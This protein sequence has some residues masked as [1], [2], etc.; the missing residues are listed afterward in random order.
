MAVN[1]KRLNQF[2]EEDPSLTDQFT[3]EE[4]QNGTVVSGDTDI[5]MEDV[6]SGYCKKRMLLE[7]SIVD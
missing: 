4:Y 3:Y 5:T 7:K 1:L 6:Y 2:L